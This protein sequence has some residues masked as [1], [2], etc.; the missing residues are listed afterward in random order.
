MARIALLMMMMLRRSMVLG[1]T[2]MSVILD[3]ALVTSSIVKADILGKSIPYVFVLLVPT[4]HSLVSA[5]SCLMV[6]GAMTTLN[7]RLLPITSSLRR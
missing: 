6:L 5:L 4:L 1:A 3:I 2:L 7:L